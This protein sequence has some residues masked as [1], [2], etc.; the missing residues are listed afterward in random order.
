MPLLAVVQIWGRDKPSGWVYQLKSW[1]GFDSPG[2]LII[3]VKLINW[4]TAGLPTPAPCAPCTPC[5]SHI[6]LSPRPD[7]PACLLLSVECPSRSQVES[8]SV[9]FEIQLLQGHTP[10]QFFTFDIVLTLRAVRL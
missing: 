1:S 3:L 6:L 9:P 5:L 2:L 10:G 8:W 4:I 7:G